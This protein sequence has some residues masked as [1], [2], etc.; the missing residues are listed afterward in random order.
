MGGDGRV[1]TDEGRHRTAGHRT[2]GH[3]TAGH[4]TAGHRTDGHRTAGQQPADRRTLWT[5]T[6][7]DRTPDGWT[8]GSRTPRPDGWTPPAGHW[9]PTPW[10]VCW[11]C[12]PRRRRPTA[13]DRLGA[14]LGR[15]RLGEQQPGPLSSKDA[16]AATPPRTG[17]A[18]AATVSCR[19]YAAVQLAPRCTAFVCWIWIVREE[20]NG[21]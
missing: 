7:G 3:R 13:R 9:R 4:R 5:T 6:P 18:T 14:P 8:A 21:T 12:R 15:R 16:G 20:G 19:W 2:A 11:Q 10:R 1:R 17:L